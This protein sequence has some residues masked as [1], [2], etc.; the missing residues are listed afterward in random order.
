MAYRKPG[1]EAPLWH[2]ASTREIAATTPRISGTMSGDFLTGTDGG[3]SIEG[4][5]GPD[6]IYG[7][8]GDDTIRGNSGQ[9]LIFGQDGADALSGNGGNDA[10]FGGEGDDTLL[11]RSGNDV[12]SA[13]GGTNLFHPGSGDDSVLGGEDTDVVRIAGSIFDFRIDRLSPT[14]VLVTDLNPDDGDEGSNRLL[15]VESVVFD[16][17]R[18]DL[19]GN[20]AP[21][22]RA[23]RVTLAEDAGPTL[24]DV[25][26]NDIDY[27]G[28]TLSVTDVTGAANGT[29][30]AQG[31][32]ILY[33]PDDD[34][35]GTETLSYR[36]FDGTTGAAERVQVVLGVTS[37]NDAPVAGDDI[38]RTNEDTSV[39]ID[40]LDDDTDVEGDTLSVTGASGASNG[41]LSV[42]TDNRVTYSPDAN[43]NGTD[44]F[45]YTV[46]DGNGGTDRA[47][48]TV[49][50][51]PV[52]DAPVAG[53]DT[54][55]T[56]EDT[57]L[58]FDPRTNDSDVDKDPL[59]I[60]GTTSPPWGSVSTEAGGGL[61]YTPVPDFNGTDTF[62]YTIND[63]NNARAT[64][65]VTV[66]VTPVNDAP[67]ANNDT[68]AAIED[69]PILIDVLAN[70]TD[71]D[72]GREGDTLSVTGTSGAT[73][74]TAVVQGD[75]TILFTPAENA[76]GTAT[77]TYEMTDSGGLT[78]TATVTVNI[79]P[80]DD[81][82]ILQTSPEADQTVQ[83]DD[84]IATVD[85]GARVTE[86]DG[87]ALAFSNI[88][89]ERGALV[90]P[91]TFNDTGFTFD[92]EVL[93]LDEGES[94]TATVSYDVTDG[95]T[96]QTG[97]FELTI[98]GADEVT[99]EPPEPI[100]STA[101]D[102]AV[103]TYT[104]AD[105]RPLL[106][107]FDKLITD[108][109]G[110]EKEVVSLNVSSDEP[111][112]GAMTIADPTV[113]S[114]TFGEGGLSFDASQYPYSVLFDDDSLNGQTVTL[115]YEIELQE[116]GGTDTIATRFAVDVVLD[117]PDAPINTA[118]DARFAFS[119]D[120]YPVQRDNAGNYAGPGLVQVDAEG[121][122]APTSLSFDLYDFLSDAETA[123]TEL[124]V[125]PG[126]FYLFRNEETG[127]ADA[128]PFEF[129]TTTTPGGAIVTID[130]ADIPLEDGESQLGHF[131]FTV[132]DGEFTSEG[133]ITLEF[134]DAAEV[135]PSVLYTF[136]DIEVP[137]TGPTASIGFLG[138]HR[139]SGSAS[140][141]DVPALAASRLGLDL[142]GNLADDGGTQL[143]LAREKEI[144][145]PA[146]EP[147]DPEEGGRDEG[148][149]VV[150][151][152][153][154]FG[155]FGAG[156]AGDLEAR[157]YV[158]QAFSTSSPPAPPSDEEVRPQLDLYI[159]NN[160]ATF[161]TAVDEFEFVAGIASDTGTPTDVTLQLYTVGYEIVTVSEGAS[162]A[163]YQIYA[164]YEEAGQ[165][166]Q[167][168]APGEQ[169][170]F[171]GTEDF[172]YATLE[173][174][175]GSPVTIDNLALTE[176][177]M[178]VA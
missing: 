147:Q 61:T 20:N 120:G 159:A 154:P 34:F 149:T 126:P 161:G 106:V 129:D 115:N 116:A 81:A 92:P 140:V 58:S 89:I 119:I 33:T 69:T 11:G 44:T 166:T 45:T 13:T 67:V 112:I 162:F 91:A 117:D 77:F 124:D 153:D 164:V 168:V 65:T 1:T 27:D 82:P 85:L 21:I 144:L 37:V 70:D 35:F 114:A 133:R 104:E 59:V 32:G 75:N 7:G 176:V 123:D 150:T 175:D 49:T 118:P 172:Y 87:D 80:V 25:T 53:N 171:S 110:V 125:T 96:S 48:V 51:D 71:V 57:P 12:L 17:L 22:G 148:E 10:L 99:P 121:P 16:D 88:Q 78:D 93:E 158:Y 63:G 169:I 145:G 9:D 50:V 151:G 56:A 122:D 15:N 84:G 167:S 108:P 5:G 127:V 98:E 42:G 177:V 38:A 18:L 64:A 74:G 86:V 8:A 72:I 29:A 156:A 39:V 73:L 83:E 132:S 95:T 30:V 136:E 94:Y 170:T 14:F 102:N 60:S 46:S 146:P 6:T 139:L 66:I 79:A 165:Y 31:G 41:W 3:D 131:D 135:N 90:I 28:D 54:V 76:T 105:G 68:I 142:T 4:L 100:A 62:T 109:D 103:F 138:D 155:I 128:L 152:V 47:T 24:I 134:L 52:N 113:V 55:T 178:D 107:P 143:L 19:T 174:A 36:V 160:P 130:F 43:F 101:I 26:A 137:D 2:T 111:S 157:P 23:D 97:S 40:V 173:A 141:V 163:I